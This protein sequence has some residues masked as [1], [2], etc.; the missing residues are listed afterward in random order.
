VPGSYSSRC[1]HAHLNP[2]QIPSW[3]QA[4]DRK[5]CTQRTGKP[6][7]PSGLHLRY[8]CTC[9]RKGPRRGGRRECA[10]RSPL[11]ACL[12]A[13]ILS[14]A[15]AEERR[16]V[17]AARLQP[18]SSHVAAVLLLERPWHGLHGRLPPVSGCV[19]APPDFAL[20]KSWA[21]PFV[22]DARPALRTCSSSLGGTARPAWS[23][24]RLWLRACGSRTA[25]TWRP[26]RQP[27]GRGRATQ[28]A[29]AVNSATPRRTQCSGG[30]PPPGSSTLI[31]KLVLCP[32][33][34]SVPA[35]CSVL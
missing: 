10:G 11:S 16:L 2:R 28:N 24:S 34:D 7:R 25:R 19:P 4:H 3:W 6:S 14:G 26:E 21:R 22:A 1:P 29:S 31:M 18:C 15:G 17:A 12:Q 23:V 9:R 8:T 27:V 33:V 5:W 35:R 13:P 30:R 20:C 32:V